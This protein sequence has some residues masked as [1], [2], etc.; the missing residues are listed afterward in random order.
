MGTL[1]IVTLATRLLAQSNEPVRLALIVETGE[2]STVSDVLTAQLSGNSKIH[3]LER[4]E[5]EKVYREQGLSAGNKDYLK[6]G[7]ILGA[8]GLLL[9]DVVRTKQA[10]NLTTRLIAVK[11]AV[12]LTDGSFPWP[13]KD[14]TSWAESVSTYLNSFLPKLTILVKDA[15]PISVVNLRSAV[16]SADSQET[17]RQLK[18]LAI[19]RLSQERQ[20]FVLE[21]QRMQL[22]SEEKELKTDESAFWNG[23]YLLEGIVDQNGYSKDVI[24]INARLTPPKG[25]EPLLIEV[26]GSRTNLSEVVNQLAVK[27]NE[28]LKVNS[29]VPEWNAADEAAQYFDEAKW[30]LKWGVY[31]EAQAAAD[32]AWALG[33]HDMDCAMVR[34]RSYMVPLDTGGYQ[35]GEFTNP[36]NTNQ[37]IQAAVEEAAPNHPWG[38]TL[39]EQIYGGTKVVQYVFAG[40]FPNPTSIDFATHALELYYEFSRTLPSG[41]PKVDSAW[42]RLGIEDLAVASQVLQHFYFVPESQKQVADKLAELRSLA[43]SVADWISRSPSVHDGYFVGDRITT[44]DE[45]ANTIEENENIFSCKVNWG[46]F[47]QDKPEDCVALYR[48]LMSS[49]VFSYIHKDLWLRKLQT[50][51]LIAWNEE[52]RKRV[53]VVWDG[54]VQELNASSNVL[55]QLEAKA[56]Q[57]ADA[58]DEKSMA[59]SFTNLFNNILENRDTLVA[60]NVE[61][62]YLDWG[63]GDLVSAKTGNGVASDIKDSLQH[64][65]YSEYSPKLGAMDRE[66]WAKTVPAGQFLSVF[67]KQKRYLKENK[68]YDFFEFANLFGTR[69]FSKV[70]ALE[71]QPLLAVYKSNLVA[72]SQNASGRQKG[73]LMGAIAQVGFLE[74]DVSRIL[75]PPSP[76]PKVE[77]A[78]KP[79][80]APQPAAIAKT[81]VAPAVSTNAPEIVTHVIVANKFLA[82]PVERLINPDSSERIEY[83]QATIT[84]HHWFEGRL[85]LDYE[86]NAGIQ[87]LDKNGKVMGGRNAGGPAVAIFDPTIAHW[88]VIDCPEVEIQVKNNFYHRSA[89]WHGELFNCDGGQ[90]KRYDFQNQQWQVLAVS[91]GNNYELFTV[92]GQLY[93]AGRNL[94]FEILE[95]GKSTRI[96][97]SSR[98]NPPASAL[99]R[100]DLGIPTLFEGP[101]HSL[102]VCTAGKIFTWT[103]NDWHEDS[104]APSASFQPEII[105]DGLLFRYADLGWPDLIS[106]LSHLAADTNAPELYLWQKISTANNPAAFYQS[107][108]RAT[109][110]PKPLWTIPPD[111]LLAHLPVAACRSG[112]YLLM[113]HSE[114]QEI[115]NDQHVVVQEKVIA[116]DGCNAALLCFSHDLP[117]PQ[118]LFLKFDAPD[119]CPP[120]AGIDPNSRGGFPVLPPAWMLATTNIFFLGLENPRN[121]IPAFN[122]ADRI[123][124]GYKAGIWLLP[125]SQIEPEIAAQKQIQLARL[126]KDKA[127]AVAVAEQ[128]RKDS[129]QRRKEL[130]AKYDHNHNGIIDP[131]EKEEAL[132]DPDFIESELDKIDANHNGWLDAE[133]LAWFDT[134]QNK[135]LEPKE[136]AGIDIAQHLLAERLLKRFN[137]NGDGFL[138]R[139]EFNELL[140]SSM[141]TRIPSDSTQRQFTGAAQSFST[142]FPDDNRDGKIDL[143]ELE[144]FLKQ[145]TR[146]GLRSRRMPDAAF[147]N[148]MRMGANQ[149]VDRR[150]L[151]KVAV[152]SY[153]QNPDS[154]T[155]RTQSNK[156]P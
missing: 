118:K 16:Q 141:G 34:V 126:T 51:R 33:R 41:D 24:T 61:V 104:A 125:V 124:I 9:F 145:Q 148:Q 79:N 153:W 102:R 134:N 121:S 32:S 69:E 29:T 94:I 122:Q 83:S 48:E 89:L 112:L 27:V 66:Y 49:P 42:Y 93:A 59:T 2:A 127:D 14:T 8:D 107:S 88:D 142:S 139:S 97:A 86:Y 138:D 47:W 77:P 63:T 114:I 149:P 108:A 101:N 38:L 58:A 15:I 128:Q 19:Q 68:P 132:D 52:G 25:G 43:R 1:A 46:C 7:Q 30:A 129:E 57:L 39:R 155:N 54:F 10:T 37:V 91:D 131:D 137:A 23:S 103:G 109:P 85:L 5:I 96:L 117:L 31:S 3:L 123:G 36:D 120:A 76:K 111:L 55:L 45:L 4:N 151:F 92:N 60:N 17:E 143:G 74:N 106:S 75:N 113:N 99:D 84:A 53:P 119:G 147:F 146:G 115:A 110:P 133:E 44:H 100:E 82:I 72:Q 136:Q 135:I 73:K 6:L 154:V 116:K 71:I 13:L 78:Q 22:L 35:E 144:T 18:L 21:R 28:A 87:Q 140:Q 130:L 150:L 80:P 81:V 64:L 20:L 105:P 70:Q 67:E 56:V 50:P 95:G 156:T 40:K 62:L 12:V 26:S 11:P 90:I 152:E 98:R 65:F